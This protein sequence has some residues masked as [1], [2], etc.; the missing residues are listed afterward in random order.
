MVVHSLEQIFRKLNEAGAR[1]LVAGGLA[2]VAHGYVRFTN[3]VDLVL[4]LEEGNCRRAIQALASLGYKPLVPVELEE[5]ASARSRRRWAE[6]KGAKVF[7]LFSDEHPQTRIDL[8][9]ESPFDFEEA[10][11]RCHWQEAARGIR[12]PFVGLEELIGMKRRAGRPQDL[13][14]VDKL[15]RLRDQMS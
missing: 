11:E 10:F 13:L 8:F 14:D 5:F 12:V 6:E 1:Y 7:Q 4:D 2:V 9:L 15:E 3:D